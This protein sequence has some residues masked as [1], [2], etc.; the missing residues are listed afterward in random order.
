MHVATSGSW[1][2][3]P[4][5]TMDGFDQWAALT[6]GGSVP[7]PRSSALLSYYWVRA[8]RVA[9]AAHALE[10][11]ATD[12][13]PVCRRDPLGAASCRATAALRCAGTRVGTSTSSSVLRRRTVRCGSR[14]PP[15]P[16]PPPLAWRAIAPVP[17]PRRVDHNQSSGL[18]EIHHIYI[19][20]HRP[21]FLI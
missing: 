16:P 12:P 4:G 11:L 14:S 1:R 5:R 15:P 17:S 13:P 18:T 7:S 2:P 10:L 21:Y 8:Q 6:S 19:Y 3:T 20:S 9:S